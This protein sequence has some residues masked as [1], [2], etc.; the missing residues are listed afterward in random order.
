[1]KNFCL[2]YLA[3]KPPKCT[4]SNLSSARRLHRTTQLT[5]TTLSGQEIFQNLTRAPRVVMAASIYHSLFFNPPI[6]PALKFEFLL[7]PPNALGGEPSRSR[8]RVSASDSTLSLVASGGSGAERGWEGTFLR[9]ADMVG[10]YGEVERECTSSLLTIYTCKN[11]IDK[12]AYTIRCATY[13]QQSFSRAR[14][15]TRGS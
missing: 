11:V 14:T 2:M 12:G 1:M 5:Y 6:V 15:W 3:A 13:S 9:V 4:S 10:V 7:F 8:S